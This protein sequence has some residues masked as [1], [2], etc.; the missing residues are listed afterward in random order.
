MKA[1]SALAGAIALLAIAAAA[2]SAAAAD[3]ETGEVETPEVTATLTVPAE[4]RYDGRKPNGCVTADVT[5][6]VAGAGLAAAT[7]WEAWITALPA[8]EAE[9]GPSDEVFIEGSA[10]DASGTGTLRFCGGDAAE[11]ELTGSVS[12]YS[13]DEEADLPIVDLE[14]ATLSLV[15]P[16]A[17]TVTVKTSTT[18]AASGAVFTATACTTEAGVPLRLQLTGHGPAS[19]VSSETSTDDDGCLTVRYRQT[20]AKKSKQVVLTVTA[21]SAATAEFRAAPRTSAKVRISR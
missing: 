15:A 6:A 21:W 16:A 13:D 4:V 10:D 2:P 7:S 17:P 11:L 18:R 8:G 1:R 3:E 5:V 12:L 20:L 9:D 14:P 19:K